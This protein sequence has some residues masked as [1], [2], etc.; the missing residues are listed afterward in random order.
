VTVAA[1]LVVRQDHRKQDESALACSIDP[2]WRGTANRGDSVNRLEDRAAISD[3]V[4]RYAT[5]A[6]TRDWDLY[7]SCFADP[8]EYDFSSFS[9]GGP[10]TMPVALWV[11]AVKGTLLGFDVTQHLSTNH[12]FTF[13]DDDLDVATCVSQ[14]HAQH[15]V[16]AATL[17][18]DADDWCIL[19][20]H[21]TNSFRRI[22]GQWRIVRCAL[23]VTWR[24]GNP[25][26]FDVA[27]A[28]AKALLI[29]G[30]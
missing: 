5:G 4:I 19:G 24:T 30:S 21:Y 12:V 3:V 28:R 10:N 25:A 17:G 29:Q 13:D 2:D 1:T 27:R 7:A 8:C 23:N 16:S 14:M 20:G 6:D 26:L 9:G 11:T 15:W 22:D 18:A